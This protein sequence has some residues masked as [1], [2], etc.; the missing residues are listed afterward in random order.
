[1]LKTFNQK[2][3]LI[4]TSIKKKEKKEKKEK[5]REVKVVAG[6]IEE[7]EKEDKGRNYHFKVIV[8]QWMRLM[9]E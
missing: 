2:V 5:K 6:R 9:L 8:E 7:L 4:A 3:S 1:M